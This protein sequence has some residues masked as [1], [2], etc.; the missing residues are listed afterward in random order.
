MNVVDTSMLFL[1]RSEREHFEWRC[2]QSVLS[3]IH[4]IYP[5]IN[6]CESIHASTIK[7]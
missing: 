1:S 5:G 7:Q 6:T 3:I 2:K 4:I